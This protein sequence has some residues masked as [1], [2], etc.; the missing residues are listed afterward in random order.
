MTGFWSIYITILT[1]GTMLALAWL[2]FATRKGQ[3]PDTTD[4]TM[5]H[6]FDGIEEYDNPLPRWWFLLFVSTLVFGAIYLVLYPGL[7]PGKACCR[8]TRAAGPRSS[9]G[10]VKWIAPTP[11][12]ARCS[13]NTRPCRSPK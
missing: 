12:S 1:V 5:G 13:P 9:S 11:N 8:V 4:Q 6:S 10:S 7:A 3:R 2:I